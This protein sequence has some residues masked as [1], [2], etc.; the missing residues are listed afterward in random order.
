MQVGRARSWAPEAEDGYAYWVY[1]D[2]VD[3][4]VRDLAAAGATIVAEPAD[5]PC[6]ERVA[7][8][9]DP[10]GNLVHLGQVL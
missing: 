9:R 2:D 6:G 4:T 7:Q 5:Q 8:T 10:G 1:V 3:D